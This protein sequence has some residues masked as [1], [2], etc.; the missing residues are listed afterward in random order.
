[1]QTLRRM[2]FCCRHMLAG[3]VHADQR[4]KLV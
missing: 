2:V 3:G 4:S 1:M